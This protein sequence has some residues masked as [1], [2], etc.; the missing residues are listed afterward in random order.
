MFQT[1]LKWQRNHSKA[2]SNNK[3]HLEKQACQVTLEVKPKH[4]QITAHLEEIKTWQT[5]AANQT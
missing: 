2:D 1:L 5:E 4:H 3:L